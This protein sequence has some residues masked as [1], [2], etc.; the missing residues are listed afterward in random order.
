MRFLKKIVD[1]SPVILI[2]AYLFMYI[3]IYF[4]LL[5]SNRLSSTCVADECRYIQFAENLLNGFY[6]PP[7]PNINLWSGPGFPIFLM[8]FVALDISRNILILVNIFLSFFSIIA[9][10]YTAKIYL[11]NNQSFIVANIWAFYYIHYQEI[12]TVLSE[13]LAALLFIGVFFYISRY[14]KYKFKKDILIASL[15]LGWLVL[16]KVILS[17]VLIFALIS[18]SFFCIFKR[19]IH[20]S[21]LSVVLGAFLVTVPYQIYTYNLTGKI[22][23]FANSGGSA[24]YFM[25]SPFPGE[26]GEWNNGSFTANCGHNPG[27]PCNAEQFAKNHGGFFDSL[28]LMSPVKADEALKKVAINNII[29]YPMKYFKN[30]INNF[31]RMLFNIP[32]SYYYQQESTIFRII[33]NAIL[34]TFILI[35]LF[36]TINLNKHFP[37][38]ILYFIIFIGIYLFISLLVSIYPRQFNIIV[39]GILIWVFYSVN[40]GLSIISKSYHEQ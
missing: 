16:T 22:F 3:L 21:V 34:F 4:W 37:I 7:P 11:S 25:T 6:S 17:Y 36:F 1:Y 26:F 39:P 40:I 9:T 31:S 24:L 2:Y 28:K 30:Y 29:R 13:P 18:Y 27:V 14:F 32:N 38:S 20:F 19:V 10:Y 5:N 8:P 15:L 35:A 23:Y 12:F 33:P